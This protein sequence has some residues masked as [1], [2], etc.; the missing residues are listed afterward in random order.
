MVYPIQENLKPYKP[1]L[2]DTVH[3]D[4]NKKALLILGIRIIH[5][6]N[7]VLL[8]VNFE[9]YSSDHMQTLPNNLEMFTLYSL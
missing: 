4:L 7:L 2:C 1:R 6:H 9:M 5:F 3:F 8:K